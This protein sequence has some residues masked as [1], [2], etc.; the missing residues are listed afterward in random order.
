M[1]IFFLSLVLCLAGCATTP[2]AAYPYRAYLP[3][4]Y[5]TDLARAYPLIVYLH[6]AD[7]RFPSESIIPDFVHGAPQLPFIVV[8]PR[9]DGEWSAARLE[10]VLDEVEKRYRIDPR[11]RYLTGLSMGARGAA[12]L[13]AHM[14]RYFAAVA[15]IAGAGDPA[16][17]CELKRVP[18]WLIHNRHDQV[19]PLEVSENF[20]QAL[21]YCQGRA[22]ITVN[23]AVSAG[24]WNHDAWTEA[25]TTPALYSWL[26][27]Q[28]TP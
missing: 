22:T 4:G 11:R 27:K 19:V 21:D 28:E 8:T 17:A 18:A 5:D 16:T 10:T 25:Y 14:P 15:L 7:P 13:G 9:S 23:Q 26:L 24:R 20:K 1:R 12:K 2:P 3:P 6:G